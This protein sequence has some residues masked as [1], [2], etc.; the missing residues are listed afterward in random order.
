MI[1]FGALYIATTTLVVIFKKE[2][3]PENMDALNLVESYQLVWKIICLKPIQL[4]I[5]VVFTLRVYFKLLFYFKYFINLKNKI[6][7]LF[8]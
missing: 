7:K 5:L 8:N 3:Q 6:V 1:F 2:I 4:I